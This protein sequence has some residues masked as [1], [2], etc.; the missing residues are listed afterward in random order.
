MGNKTERI[1]IRITPEMKDALDELVEAVPGD[2]SD[3]MRAA[4]GEYLERRR[5]EQRVLAANG[6]H[7]EEKT[8]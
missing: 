6:T 8:E 3:V 2:Q 1:T 5:A 4:L 7:A